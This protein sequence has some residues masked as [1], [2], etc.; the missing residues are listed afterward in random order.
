MKGSSVLCAP[1]LMALLCSCSTTAPKDSRPSFECGLKLTG[2]IATDS[3]SLADNLWRTLQRA[4]RPSSAELQQT[5]FAFIGEVVTSK[6]KFFVAVQRLV[7]IGMLAPRGQ[8]NLLLFDSKRRLV[9]SFS[10]LTAVPLWC[11]GSRIYLAGNGL[12]SG[13]PLDRR[14]AAIENE[15]ACGG[16]VIDFTGGIDHPQITREKKY[17]SSGGIEDDPWQLDGK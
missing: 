17:G 12:V 15:A 16:N 10:L 9:K 5:Q 6:G 11:E 13:M 4:A 14:I 3:S 2:E 1:F 8:G 7:R